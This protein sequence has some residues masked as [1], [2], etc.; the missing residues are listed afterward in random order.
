MSILALNTL[1]EYYLAD[2]TDFIETLGDDS[3]VSKVYQ[4]LI[5][6]VITDIQNQFSSASQSTIVQLDMDGNVLFSNNTVKFAQTKSDIIKNRGSVE[7]VGSS[8]ILVADPDGKRALIIGLV[9]TTDFKDSIATQFE[10]GSL[11]AEDYE[12]INAV[13]EDVTLSVAIS[14]TIWQYDSPLMVNGFRLVPR[15]DIEVNI[16]DSH[17]DEFDVFI[18][19]NSNIIWKNNS[20]SPISIY[21]GTT[22]YDVF[23]QDPDLTIY[24]QDFASGVIEPG[25]SYTFQ[26]NDI[27]EY[28]Y[29]TYPDILTGKIAVTENRLSSRDEFVVIENDGLNSPFSSRVIKI[30]FSGNVIFSFGEGYLVKPNSARPLNNGGLIIS[31]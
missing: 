1:M 20:A 2:P 11:S 3:S 19:Q 4:G 23:Q 5:E 24:G 28:N 8:E 6:D 30:D 27:G 29:F 7:K 10:A 25:E 12:F 14:Q 15:N 16:Y 26:F 18:R 31:V 22:S 17:I 9:F 21:S 13:F